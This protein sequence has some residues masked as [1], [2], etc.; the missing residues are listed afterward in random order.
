MDCRF[1]HIYFELLLYFYNLHVYGAC[2][3]TQ[4]NCVC[5]YFLHAI[6]TPFTLQVLIFV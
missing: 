2:A 1:V 6:D 3:S 5:Q 4:R